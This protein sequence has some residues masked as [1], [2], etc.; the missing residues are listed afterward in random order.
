MEGVKIKEIMRGMDTVFILR[1]LLALLW[2]LFGN[3]L[4]LIYR[5]AKVRLANAEGG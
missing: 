2:L 4:R 1:L 5:R 3:V